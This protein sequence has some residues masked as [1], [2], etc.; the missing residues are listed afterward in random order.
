MFEQAAVGKLP[1]EIARVAN[2]QGWRTK[3]TTGRHTGK[4]HGGGLWTARQ[5]LATLRNPA[6]V[7]SFREKSGVRAGHH[8]PIVSGE[9]FGSVA[10][11][12]QSRRTRAPGKRYNIDWPFKSR[13]QCAICERPMTPHLIRYKNRLYRYYRCRSTA[14]GRRP[15]GHQVCAQDIER[16]VQQ[17]FWINWRVTLESNQLRDYVQSGIYDW[18]DGSIRAS[19]IRPEPASNA[20]KN[21]PPP[22]ITARK[23]QTR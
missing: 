5:V 8:E 10:D 1:A 3:I 13:I 9:I 12:L 20:A 11:Q 4:S 23:R 16:A 6:Y 7:G 18:R 17:Q 22:P 19:L 14:G 21:E 2:E 15:C